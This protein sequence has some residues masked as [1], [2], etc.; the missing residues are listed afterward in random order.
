MARGFDERFEAGLRRIE[1]RRIQIEQGQDAEIKELLEKLEQ[2][3]AWAKAWRAYAHFEYKSDH[4]NAENW[5]RWQRAKKELDDLRSILASAHDSERTAMQQLR[6][7]Q[8]LITE[9]RADI[10][11]KDAALDR[12][13]IAQSYNGCNLLFGNG[14]CTCWV[15]EM[16]A[17]LE[18]QTAQ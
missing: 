1:E 7:A 18:P 13:I 4:D 15:C 17:A 11:R 9:L 12:A 16:R 14:T 10:A 8:A 5:L 2:T 3:R 6:N